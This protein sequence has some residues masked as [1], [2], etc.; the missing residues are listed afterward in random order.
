MRLRPYS[1][2]YT[3]L[4]L[5]LPPVTYKFWIVVWL[6][7]AVAMPI[8]ARGGVAS[9]CGSFSSLFFS[10]R[11]RVFGR[12]RALGVVSF[13]TAAF[14]FSFSVSCL[15]AI[16]TRRAWLAAIRYRARYKL[17]D[18]GSIPGRSGRIFQWEGGEMPKHPLLD[19]R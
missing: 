4:L 12:H 3:L 16:F 6:T 8:E 7:R 14:L 5:L 17:K 9:R 11:L 19:L 13:E 2:C 1:S 18:V 15:V 10:S